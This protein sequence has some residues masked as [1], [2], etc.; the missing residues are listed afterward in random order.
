MKIIRMRVF[1]TCLLNPVLNIAGPPMPC[2][3]LSLP[4]SYSFLTNPRPPALSSSTRF[5]QLSVSCPANCIDLI[6]TVHVLRSV[7]YLLC[8]T[9]IQFNYSSIVLYRALKECG[10][11]Y[12]SPCVLGTP[13]HT[14]LRRHTDV[15]APDNFRYCIIRNASIVEVLNRRVVGCARSGGCTSV[16]QLPRCLAH[17]CQ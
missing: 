8:D 14:F 12:S 16:S 4:L 1:E 5:A 17:R 11:L 2:A 3:A 9:L 15:H 6:P 7:T 13:S 10:A